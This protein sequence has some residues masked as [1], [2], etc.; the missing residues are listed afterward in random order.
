MKKILNFIISAC[1]IFLILYLANFIL[2]ITKIAFPSP[3]LG[4]IIFFV[5]LKTGLIKEN[6]VEDF[7]NFMLKNMILFFIPV[8]VGV[9]T[10]GD[11][12]SK[13]FLAILMTLL[14]TT[15]L[16]IVVVGL[17]NH[18]IVKYSRYLRLKRRNLK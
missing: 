4:L 2:K 5:L 14:I 7:C 9:M 18:N 15:T 12:F 16:I 11:I 17:F 3:I 1:I 6:L 13:N 8:F 10:Y